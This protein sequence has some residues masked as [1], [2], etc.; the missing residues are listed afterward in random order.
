MIHIDSIIEIIEPKET[1]VSPIPKIRWKYN[2]DIR[3]TTV[4]IL[5]RNI[6]TGK[7]KWYHNVSAST[8]EFIPPEPLD[9]GKYEICIYL[10][11]SSRPRSIPRKLAVIANEDIDAINKNICTSVKLRKGPVAIAPS[12]KISG[13][14]LR[15]SWN[16]D[17]A[18]VESF[19]INVACHDSWK[20]IK[21]FSCIPAANKELEISWQDLKSIGSGKFVWWVKGVYVDEDI[22]SSECAFEVPPQVTEAIDDKYAKNEFQIGSLLSAD[23]KVTAADS[24]LLQNVPA[25]RKGPKFIKPEDPIKGPFLLEWSCSDSNIHH[26]E[27]VIVNEKNRDIVFRQNNLPADK[28]NLFFDEKAL[29]SLGYTK[30]NW[31]IRSHYTEGGY[32]I[33]SVS[34]Q[35]SSDLKRKVDKS[36]SN[37]DKSPALVRFERKRNT[38][39]ASIYD[40]SVKFNRKN[41]SLSGL[42]KKFKRLKNLKRLSK[43]P[44]WA[45]KNVS[46]TLDEGDILG[47]VGKNGAGKSTLLRILTGVLHPDK[48][49]VQVQGQICSLLSL[50][51]GFLPD[52]S[53]RDNIY[54]NSMYLGLN[55]NRVNDIIDQI[56]EFAEL[57][58]FID[59]QLKHYSSGM[60]ARLGFSVA[61]HAEPDI[62]VIDEVLSTGDKDFRKKAENKMIEF[63]NQAKSIVMV[64]HNTKMVSDFCTKCL[65]LDN[66]NAIAF[67]PTRDVLHQYLES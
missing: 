49:S 57:E 6:V 15:F 13:S 42:A 43:Q 60:K 56:I 28:P 45:L 5:L 50:G 11:L 62:L 61:V 30:L 4:D 66:G 12:G 25:Y 63:M 14:N 53:G 39:T 37:S 52:L 64:S 51:T 2:I 44:F 35:I 59:N 24:L 48:G 31:I 32:S 34:I 33:D 22:W 47:I 18:D 54:L 41:R 36:I 55:K 58:S 27:I 46:F 7:P 20:L 65:F 17:D 19:L 9:E 16:C 3:P 8:Q 67:G 23:N 40:V 1:F 29:S 10:P 21:T 26:Y 38:R